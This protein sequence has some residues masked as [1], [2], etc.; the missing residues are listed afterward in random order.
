MAVEA[1]AHRQR[2]GLPHQR[3]VVDLRRGR[4]CSRRRWRRAP[5]DRNRRSRAAGARG[6]VQRLV[7]GQ[8]LAHRRQHRGI[9]EELRM[10]GHAGGGRRHA[11]ERRCLDRGVAIAAID[12]E[13]A[14]VMRVAERHRL[15][16][17][18]R[19]VG[20]VMRAPSAHRRR[21]SATKGAIKIAT[22]TTRAIVS[23]TGRKSCGMDRDDPRPLRQTRKC[24]H[25]FHGQGAL[26][27][28][29]K[30]HSGPAG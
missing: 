7:L 1:P 22:S 14:D 26:S 9:G 24:P 29:D 20:H 13:A 21:Q 19:L 18:D 30:L 28:C 4:W 10:A 6:P 12:A 3:H 2:R 15:M 8:A 16:P 23:A 25:K 17:G 5:S 27:R 11:G